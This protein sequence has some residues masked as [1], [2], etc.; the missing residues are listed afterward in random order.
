M[1]TRI[2]LNIIFLNGVFDV[3]ISKM[4]EEKCNIAIFGENS[5]YMTN[6]SIRF[7]NNKQLKNLEEF[8]KLLDSKD[9]YI[10]FPV[11]N[12]KYT[13][14]TDSILISELDNI[15]ENFETFEGEN[16]IS[17]IAENGQTVNLKITYYKS[18]KLIHQDLQNQIDNLKALVLE[19]GG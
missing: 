10:I 7:F 4:S 16:N 6:T 17:V 15:R 11:L 19:N 18:Q 14:I 8:K 13:K 9:V 2:A 3:D 1:K 5:F 12:P